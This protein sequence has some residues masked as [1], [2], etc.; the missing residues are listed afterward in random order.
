MLWKCTWN[1]WINCKCYIRTSNN[2]CWSTWVHKS[3]ERSQWSCDFHRNIEASIRWGADVLS[4]E[5]QDN[6]SFPWQGKEYSNCRQIGPWDGWSPVE[7]PAHHPARGVLN[8]FTSPWRGSSLGDLSHTTFLIMHLEAA[9]A[10]VFLQKC[11]Q[12]KGLEGSPLWESTSGTVSDQK[13][14]K[15]QGDVRDTDPGPCTWWSD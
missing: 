12:F 10:Q 3:V 6:R 13:D 2:K 1:R 7:G 11:F 8:S 4:S 14:E 9:Q 15:E 5:Q